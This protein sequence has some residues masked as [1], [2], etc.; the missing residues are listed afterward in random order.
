MRIEST[1][2]NKAHVPLQA[3]SSKWAAAGEVG[4]IQVPNENVALAVQGLINRGPRA[5]A[6]IAL[7]TAD[8]ARDS[9]KHLPPAYQQLVFDHLEACARGRLIEVLRSLDV[10]TDP[11]LNALASSVA[12]TLAAVEAEVERRK[13]DDAADDEREGEDV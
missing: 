10:A 1:G 5:V 13:A 7:N 4:D 8:G 9:I 12:G 11:I 3:D 2:G 6:N